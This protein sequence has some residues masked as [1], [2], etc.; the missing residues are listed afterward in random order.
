MASGRV[1]LYRATLTGDVLA[2][3]AANEII[4]FN[5]VSVKDTKIEN[6]F[7]T[8]VEI[9]PQEA[10]GD[11]QSPGQDFQNIQPLGRFEKL[12]VLTCF[13]SNVFGDASD[14]LNQFVDIV[15]KWEREAKKLAP[16]SEGR[17]GIDLNDLVRYNVIPTEVNPVTGLLFLEAKWKLNWNHSPARIECIIRLKQSRGDGT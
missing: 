17:H 2:T 4:D 14:G 11:N 15:E 3:L 5:N 10:T 1:R 12:Y 16:F 8:E 7:C 6:A 13:F 9:N